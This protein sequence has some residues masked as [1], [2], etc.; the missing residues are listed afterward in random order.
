MARLALSLVAAAVA[1]SALAHFSWPLR[2]VAGWTALGGTELALAFSVIASSGSGETRRLAE[3]HERGR[4]F[5]SVVIQ[6]VSAASLVFAIY[7]LRHAE[8]Y[9]RLE[10]RAINVLCVAAVAVSWL[11]TH[12]TYAARYA[13]LY[14]VEHGGLQFS[15]DEPLTLWDFVYFSY[16]VGMCFQ[17]SD[18]SLTSHAFRRVMLGHALLSFAYNTAVLALAL[19]L[20]AGA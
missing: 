11:V 14:F 8:T 4:A 6:I 7:L 3:A 2:F 1:M 20:V 16:T 5:S 15:G 19:N 9:P 17:A 12:T 18:T 13:R 10:H